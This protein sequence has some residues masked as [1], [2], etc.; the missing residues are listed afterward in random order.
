M[1]MVQFPGYRMV[2]YFCRPTREHG[3][4]A[5]FARDVMEVKIVHINEYSEELVC[6]CCAVKFNI[7][8]ST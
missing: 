2:S 1:E 5:I 8:R 4:G 7:A 3:G 6:E